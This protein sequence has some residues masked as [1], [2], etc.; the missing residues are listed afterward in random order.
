MFL[1]ICRNSYRARDFKNM[2]LWMN[3]FRWGLVLKGSGEGPMKLHHC[4]SK[5]YLK[6]LM[7]EEERVSQK[8]THANMGREMTQ[9]SSP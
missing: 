7:L 3:Y 8:P 1:V 6:V 2:C 9:F 4:W 5:I